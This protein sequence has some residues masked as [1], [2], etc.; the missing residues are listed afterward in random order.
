MTASK[1]WLIQ[2]GNLTLEQGDLRVIAVNTVT[3]ITQITPEAQILAA[4]AVQITNGYQSQAFT[5]TEVTWNADIGY[6]TAQQAVSLVA[7]SGG[8]P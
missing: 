6:V 7:P 5:Q 4:E 3:A 1:S 2:Q 8:D